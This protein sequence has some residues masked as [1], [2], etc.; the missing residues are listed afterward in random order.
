MSCRYSE[1]G[2]WNT[3]TCA[4]R[5]AYRAEC[6]IRKT[7]GRTY[8]HGRMRVCTRKRRM[9]VADVHALTRAHG[10]GGPPSISHRPFRV[11]Q[12]AF[13]PGL[14]PRSLKLRRQSNK[15]THIVRELR[16]RLPLRAL[17]LSFSLLRLLSSFVRAERCNLERKRKIR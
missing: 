2:I 13:S 5:H 14:G 11:W 3:C 16:E 17:F 8:A 1:P 10:G 6:T 12:V 4:R 15:L 7:L 9:R